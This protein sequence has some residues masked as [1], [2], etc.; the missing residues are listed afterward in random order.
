[1]H[2]VA[3]AGGRPDRLYLQNHW[4]LYRSDDGGRS[5]Q[6]RNHGIRAV[7]LPDKH[8]EFGQC[9]H[10][11]APAGGRPDRLYLQNHWGLYRSD[12]GGDHWE[13]MANGVPSDFGFPMVA[14]PSDPDTA[15]IIPLDSDEFRCTPDGQ[16]RVY[17]TRD[18]GGSWEPLTGGLP[19]RDAWLTVLRDGFATDGLDP[20]GLYFGT[21]TG[22]LFASADEGERWQA[23][24][25]WLP[26]VVCVKAAVVP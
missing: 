15:W 2:K 14:H 9:V 20:A 18:A 7:F 13:D 6:A 10:K 21:R 16:A 5:W 3:P 8:P 26:P 19:E 22:Q 11:V 17:R 24:A 12:D 23:L 4:G 1:M 25:E